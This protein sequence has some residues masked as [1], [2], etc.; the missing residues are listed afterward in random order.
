MSYYA[1][2]DGVDLKDMSDENRDARQG[3]YIKAQKELAGL[4]TYAEWKKIKKGPAGSLRLKEMG[5]P[6]TFAEA[7]ALGRSNFKDPNTAEP[8]APAATAEELRVSPDEFSILQSV[9]GKG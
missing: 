2:Q 7:A 6:T 5:L 4:I 1:E 3:A 9:K 8:I